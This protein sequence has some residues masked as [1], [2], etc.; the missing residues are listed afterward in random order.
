V[1]RTNRI[2]AWLGAVDERLAR[3]ALLGIGIHRGQLGIAK[4]DAALAP[5]QLRPVRWT[6]TDD[7]FEHQS[8]ARPEDVA[9]D[10][11]FELRL[12]VETDAQHDEILRRLLGTP[13]VASAFVAVRRPAGSLRRRA[14]RW[15]LRIGLMGYTRDAEEAVRAAIGRPSLARLLDIRRIEDDPGAVDVLVVNGP[16]SEAVS[17][18]IQL[19]PVAN[20]VVILDA[21]PDQ[22]P[23]VEALL[24]T[25]RAATSAVGS[26]LAP[27]TELPK[28][29]EPLIFEASRAEPLDIALTRAAGPELLLYAEPEGMQRAALPEIALRTAREINRAGSALPSLEPFRAQLVT[30]AG[31]ALHGESDE[32]TTIA[33]IVGAA[34]PELAQLE[35]TRWC[36]ARIGADNVLRRG[37]NEVE[38]FIGPPEPDALASSMP[39]GDEELPWE[40]EQV[41]AFRLTVLFVPVKE[42]LAVQQAELELPRLGCS[43]SVRFEL[44]VAPGVV[45]ATARIVV[46][47]RSRV[48]QTAVLR[49]RVG[50]QARLTDL[51]A[52][53]S[54]LDELDD[55]R[56]FDVALFLNET[57]GRSVLLR[58]SQGCTRVSHGGAVK[59]IAR[60]IADLLATA[61]AH[62]S[63]RLKSKAARTL[64]IELAVAGHDLYMTLE[65]ELGPLAGMDRIQVVSASPDF[66]LPIELVYEREPPDEDARLCPEYLVDPERCNGACKGVD[67]TTVICPNAFWGMSKTIE[68]LRVDPGAAAHPDDGYLLCVADRPRTGR[69]DVRIDR[70]VVGASGR[71]DEVDSAKLVAALAGAVSAKTWKDLTTELSADDTQLLVLCPHTDYEKLVLEIGRTNLTR[72]RIAA[73]YVTGGRDVKPFVVLFG[74]RTAPTP[75]DPGGFAARFIQTGARAVFHSSTDLLS[76]HA[77]ELASRLASRLVGGVDPPQLLSEAMTAFRRQAVADGYLAGLA[78]AAIGDADWAL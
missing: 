18:L 70:I 42:S 77:I 68:R 19:R 66:P 72:G 46:L 78:I 16:L 23:M 49:G 56:P 12:A 41:E 52:F 55:R 7:E 20:L 2:D 9:L 40:E 14:W 53:V 76:S 62:S 36:Q 64:L 61:A 1:I 37:S 54:D 45:T 8:M 58:G 13:S 28:L 47:F 6:L 27:R 10:P 74:C 25:A 38:V 32:A 11:G 21:A 35:A 4:L 75:D 24:S 31:D 33:D 51:A 29:I 43:P 26:A 15:P 69:R 59:P 73:R 63:L 30:A 60:G 67:D 48:L 44:T 3:R 5:R 22:S 34:E 39:F 71:V 65:D 50:R 57:S 17:H